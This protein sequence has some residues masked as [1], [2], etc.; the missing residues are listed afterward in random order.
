MG[1]LH[2]GAVAVV[3]MVFAGSSAAAQTRRHDPY[4]Y[5]QRQPFERRVRQR[6]SSGLEEGR[7]DA[8]RNRPYDYR[9]RS[10]YRRGDSGWHRRSGDR[11]WYR[12]EFRRGFEI[13]YRD[14]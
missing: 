8:R 1:R 2:L 4:Q 5:R 3:A 11:D 13:G 12:S 6:I 14:G 9:E 10:D 7:N